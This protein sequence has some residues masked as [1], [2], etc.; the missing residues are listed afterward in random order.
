MHQRKFTKVIQRCWKRRKK[1]LNR[2]EGEKYRPHVASVASNVSC[3]MM[4]FQMLGREEGCGET[5][6]QNFRLFIS[7]S[8]L[9]CGWSHSY[10]VRTTECFDRLYL[11]QRDQRNRRQREKRLSS[12]ISDDKLTELLCVFFLLLLFLLLPPISLMAPSPGWMRN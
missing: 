10:K 5:L 6:K 8:I 4:D 1:K 2:G 9:F 11:P 3:Q 7:V 12:F